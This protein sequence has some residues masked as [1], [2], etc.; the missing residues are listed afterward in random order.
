MRRAARLIRRLRWLSIGITPF[1]WHWPQ[2]DRG[3]F[4]DHIYRIGPVSVSG[5]WTD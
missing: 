1:V 2:V 3:L 5:L 4:A